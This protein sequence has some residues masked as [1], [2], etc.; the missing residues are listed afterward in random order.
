MSVIIIMSITI[1]IITMMIIIIIINIIVIII[2]I[3]LSLLLLSLLL[4]LLL[5]VVVVACVLLSI[6]CALVAWE[7][8][9]SQEVRRCLLDIIYIDVFYDV[10]VLLVWSASQEVARLSCGGAIRD[11]CLNT[12]GI[13]VL[14]G[15]YFC[16]ILMFYEAVIPD[17]GVLG[18]W[19]LRY[20]QI[21]YIHAYEGNRLCA[22]VQYY[23]Y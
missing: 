16:I 2:I 6:T 7:R 3:S 10:V 8:S 4:S 11:S 5:L 22:C 20:I 23:Y 19:Y 21:S 13:E 17:T 9:A 15:A 1:V 12:L 14:R 18:F